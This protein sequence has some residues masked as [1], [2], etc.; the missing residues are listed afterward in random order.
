MDLR[1]WPECGRLEDIEFAVV[2]QQPT[3]LLA[4]LPAL[5]AVTS[6]GA[7][8]EHVLADRDLPW[9]IP[10]GRLAGPRLAADMAAYLVAQV[11]S[12][13]R[14]LAQFP[15]LQAKACWQPFAPETVPLVG[16][17]G[18]GAMGGAAARAFQALSIP[19]EGW[20]RGGPAH[21]GLSM[22]QGADGLLELARRADY[23]ICLL[24]LTPSTRGILGADLLAGMKPGS[25]L[26]NVARGGHLDEAA[27]LQGLACG[28]PELAILDVFE[29]EPLPPDHPFWQHARVHITPH[30][31]SLSCMREAAELIAESYQTVRAGR[32]PLGLVKRQ[33][34]Y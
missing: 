10:V 11:I 6:L 28:R 34:G 23:L 18:T 4:T 31:A 22:H 21:D 9:H 13:W 19:V 17:L 33:R 3:G 8:V 27:L 20:N 14:R 12:H 1:I 7:G 25:V 5:K 16:L 29:R 32:P 2:W 24:P 30:C 15:A 26:I